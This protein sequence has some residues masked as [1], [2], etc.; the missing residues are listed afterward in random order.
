MREHDNQQT[1]SKVTRI[2]QELRGDR[3]R[4]YMAFVCF[5]IATSVGSYVQG[6]VFSRVWG[7][8]SFL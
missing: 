5:K 2:V 4:G 8:F 1:L 7:D 6:Y 3:L